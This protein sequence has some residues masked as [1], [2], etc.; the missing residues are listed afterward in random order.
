MSTLFVGRL[1]PDIR[2]RE[3][4]DVFSKYGRLV[5]CETKRGLSYAFGFVE[6]EDKRDAE[7]AL[8]ETDGR[9]VFGDTRIVVELAKGTRRGGGEPGSGGCFRCGKEGHWAR[10][11]PE[12]GPGRGRFGRSPRRRSY[13]PRRRSYSPRRRS[14]SPRRRS[15]SP[16]RGRDRRRSR[17]AS[18]G[19]RYDSRSPPRNHDDREPRDD[20]PPRD[21]YPAD[22]HKERERS[23]SRSPLR[24]G[25][26]GDM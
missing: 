6:F 8:R 7:D 20:L 10:D 1:P 13:S 4:E 3:L 26:N 23:H 2:Q 5:R 18:N 12:G 14:P 24:D 9:R 17:S 19:R 15:P 11:C 25:M 16:R 21:D 22:D